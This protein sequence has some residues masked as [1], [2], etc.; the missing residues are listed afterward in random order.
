MKWEYFVAH[1]DNATKVGFNKFIAGTLEYDGQR[2]SEK[3]NEIGK[4]GWE[5]ITI[6]E[7]IGTAGTNGRLLFVFKR[8]IL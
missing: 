2:I 4:D 7:A 5:L 8:P 3:L 1:L 6:T